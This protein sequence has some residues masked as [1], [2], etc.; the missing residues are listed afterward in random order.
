LVKDWLTSG[1]I[2]VAGGWA[3]WRFYHS[4]WLRRRAEIPSLEGSSSIP[5]VCGCGNDCVAVSLRWSWRNVG[6]RPVHVDDIRSFVEVYRLAG[7]IGSFVDPRQQKATLTPLKIGLHYPLRGYGFYIFEPNTTSSILT[8]SILPV[9]EA[10]I[11]RHRVYADRKEH[12]TGEKWQY[13]WERWQVFRT[14]A[15][16]ASIAKSLK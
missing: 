4:E 7:D 14:D 6:T 13:P 5:E 15:P 3:I 10:F 1:A 8:I 11:A 12:P 9:G 2:L 16:S